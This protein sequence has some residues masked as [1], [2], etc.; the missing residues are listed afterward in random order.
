MRR[1]A[2][3]R[4]MDRWAMART[5]SITHGTCNP[6]MTP[7]K[8]AR[9]RARLCGLERSGWVTLLYRRPH[10]CSIIASVA[11]V[12]LIAKLKNQRVFTHMA[13]LGGENVGGLAAISTRRPLDRS[14][15]PRRLKIFSR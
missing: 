12:R 7:E 10:C 8:N 1:P 13:Y 2:K 3:K 15:V 14:V 9:T 5:P 11:Y 6:S 4:N